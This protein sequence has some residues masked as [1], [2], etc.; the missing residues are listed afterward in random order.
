MWE[1]TTSGCAALAKTELGTNDVD[2]QTLDFDTAADEFAQFSMPLP[3]QFDNSTITFEVHWTAASGAGTVSWDVAALARSEGDPLD[4][5]FTDET[6]VTDTLTTA[7]DLHISPTSADMG[8]TGHVDGDYIHFRVR[9][10]VSDD[11]LGV[12]AKLLGIHFHITTDAAT[13]A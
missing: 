9:R 2:I 13:A 10:D 8:L 5:A 3:R 6:T 4:A 7:N 12:D 1:T 11:T